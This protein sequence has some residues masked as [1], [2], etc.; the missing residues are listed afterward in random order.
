MA[1]QRTPISRA[2]ATGHLALGGAQTRGVN[3]GRIE[4][5]VSA[6]AGGALTWLGLKRGG[7][8]G[9][10]LVLVGG[11]LVYR[12]LSGHC[13][14]YAS[15]GINT[16]Q[17]HGRQA[18]VA[19]GR[20]FKV[21]ESVAVKWSAEELFNIWRD[22]ENLPRFMS[23]LVQVETR[24]MHSHWVAHGPA[25]TQVSWDAEIITE[26]PG[27]MLAWRS[28]AGSQVDTAGSVHFTPLTEGG[29]TEVVV[30]LKYDLPGGAAGSWLAW[31]FGQ[32]PAHQ[33]GADLRRFKQLVE[34]GEIA[35]S[36]G[37]PA[38]RF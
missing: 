35:Y 7:L 14:V 12:G 38:R 5:L 21:V 29:G 10:G 3:V 33:V 28:L 32:D 8:F 34:S 17:S 22:F 26:D 15:A 30:T 31:M 16:A 2:I 18:S 1:T 19:A 24:G 37:R 25:G 4:R 11:G 6:A 23:H 27:R 36:A 9:T 20:G 13:D